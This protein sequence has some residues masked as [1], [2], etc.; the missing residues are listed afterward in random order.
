MNA[1]LFAFVTLKPTRTNNSVLIYQLSFKVLQ[2]E[3]FYIAL[4]AILLFL[5]SFANGSNDVS[6]AVATLAGAKI[7]SVRNAILWGTTWTAV[8]AISGLY[9]GGAI[10]KN[11]TENIYTQKPEF[12]FP[13]A[14]AVATAPIIWVLL[15]TWRGWPVSTTHAIVGGL[16]GSGV[17]AFGIEGI[18]W[19]KA[20]SNIALPLLIS[21][22]IAII[23]AYFLYPSLKKMA[24]I[25]GRTKLCLAPVPKLIFVHAGNLQT[26]NIQATDNCVVCDCDT[27]EAQTT[28]GI[29]INADNL[30][31]LTSGML[32]F[33]RGLNDTPKLVAVVLPFMLMSGASMQ[34][35]AFLISAFAM[36][37]GGLIAGQKVT[38]VLGFKVTQMDHIQGFSANAIS[39]FLVIFASKFGLP[40]STTHVSTSSIMGVGLVDGKGLNLHTV[41]SML[42]AWIVTVP[43]AALIAV[44]V[45][46][47]AGNL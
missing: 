8:G 35:W 11:I 2:M 45:Y 7:T 15:A 40:V 33:S 39:A 4:A 21:P 29:S 20:L 27:I 18:A 31:W 16:I 34:S 25:I 46:M 17:A 19:D 30:H 32:S 23:M 43:A 37:A 14:L 38:K 26:A 36:A 47:I 13:L 6:K 3:I 22:V 1:P 44:A 10:I 42:L 28:A 24:N 12:I 41:K 5:L 9:L